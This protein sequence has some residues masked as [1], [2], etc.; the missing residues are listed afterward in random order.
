MCP[1]MG[2][3]ARNRLRRRAIKPKTGSID[4]DSI[5]AGGTGTVSTVVVQSPPV[6]EA[7]TNDP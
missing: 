4:K 1:A 3:F 6:T 5:S 2:G 7:V